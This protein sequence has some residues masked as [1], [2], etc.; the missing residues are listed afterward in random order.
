M[1]SFKSL[2]KVHSTF[3]EPLVTGT[4]FSGSPL[5]FTIFAGLIQFDKKC[6]Q[7]IFPMYANTCLPSYNMAFLSFGNAK[8]CGI[9]ISDYIR[10]TN[11]K[12]EFTWKMI[13]SRGR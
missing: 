3:F 11:T 5:I 7:D 10:H 1:Y 9:V 13:Y 4:T 12:E 6:V 2:E 8:L